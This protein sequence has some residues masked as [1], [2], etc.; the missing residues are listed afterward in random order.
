MGIKI[1]RHRINGMNVLMQIVHVYVLYNCS[2]PIQTLAIQPNYVYQDMTYAPTLWMPQSTTGHYPAS[3]TSPEWLPGCHEDG[4]YTSCQSI[5]LSGSFTAHQV[6][7]VTSFISDDS[8]NHSNDNSVTSSSSGYDLV[9]DLGEL[10]AGP[11]PELLSPHFDLDQLMDSPATNTSSDTS[12]W[13]KKQKS[14]TCGLCMLVLKSREE[15]SQHVKTHH[16]QTSFSCDLCQRQFSQLS[17]LRTHH[18]KHT[19]ERP[20]MC[21][22][23][24]RTFADHS[25]F[26][27]HKRIHSNDRPYSCLYCPKT[28]IQSGN[29]TRHMKSIHDHKGSRQ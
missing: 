2:S 19:G 29:C 3:P 10:S 8:S 26:I 22:H 12:S 15:Y 1:K 23:C 11:L 9:L 21:T 18:R 16:K 4:G 28:F 7:P 6:D 5:G 20:F 25:S 27:K 24:S 17:T 13:T 14:H